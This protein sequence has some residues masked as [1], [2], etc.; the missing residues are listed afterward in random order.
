MLAPK[1]RSIGS[2][3]AAGVPVVADPCLGHAADSAVRRPTWAPQPTLPARP[4]PID[5]LHVDCS[6]RL[7]GAE[8]LDRLGLDER[9]ALPGR[10]R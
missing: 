2:E 7:L 4:R 5:E 1:R 10:F 8:A 9:E 6:L 3:S